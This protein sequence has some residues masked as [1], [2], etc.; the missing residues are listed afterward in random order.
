[1]HDKRIADEAEYT[2]PEGSILAQD[3]G[4]Q[5][6]TLP[7]V[8]ILQPKKKPRK[9]A[10]TGEAKADNSGFRTSGCWSSTVLVV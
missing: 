7:G 8:I 2:L 9:G 4:I 1:M 6:C 10:L 5:G 3:S